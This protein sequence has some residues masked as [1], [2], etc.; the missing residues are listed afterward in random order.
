[1]TQKTRFK[2]G[3]E[4][5][6]DFSRL[7]TEHVS[8]F[9]PCGISQNLCFF[10]AVFCSWVLPRFL[11]RKQKIKIKA[12]APFAPLS[13]RG[14]PHAPGPALGAD[15]PLR[16]AAGALERAIAREREM[17]NAELLQPKVEAFPFPWLL[18]GNILHFC[19]LWFSGIS[20]LNC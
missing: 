17:G 10:A 11:F 3:N 13:R 6:I 19:L 4:S 16:A 20:S 2:H 15:A 14:L 8:L 9:F 1:M 7:T 5:M 18:L 12:A